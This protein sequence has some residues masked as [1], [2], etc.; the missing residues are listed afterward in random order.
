MKMDSQLKVSLLSNL[1]L[2]FS[3][4]TASAGIFFFFF[5]AAG[6]NSYNLVV[7]LKN[8]TYAFPFSGCP[9]LS[10]HFPDTY[11]AKYHK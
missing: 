8:W 1:D 4:A 7:H 5:K 11:M 6:I 2:H 9:K 3:I 10:N